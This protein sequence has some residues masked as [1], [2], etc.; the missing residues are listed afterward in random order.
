M[1]ECCFVHNP[2]VFLY[3]VIAGINEDPVTGSAH[4]VLGPYFASKLGKD[5]VVGQQM[6][7]RGGFIECM[8]TDESVQLTGT[9]ITAMSGILWM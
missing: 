2:T 9:A 7:A 8:I 5:S 1:K 4:C 3:S 6:S